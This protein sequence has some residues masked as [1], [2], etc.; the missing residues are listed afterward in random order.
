MGFETIEEK[1]SGNN[2]VITLKKQN[3]D[4]NEVVVVG[5]GQSEKREI[6][7]SISKVGSQLLKNRPVQSFESALQGR[8]AGVVI[9]NTS[10]KVG[11]GIKVRIRGTSSISASA[12]PICG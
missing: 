6:T 10:G 7:G 9:E 1:I 11:Q 2:V 12:S 5:Y 4:L 8:A 3:T